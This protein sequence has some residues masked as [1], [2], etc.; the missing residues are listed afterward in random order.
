MKQSNFLSLNWRDL[1]RAF[2]VALITFLLDFA[3]NVFLPSLNIPLEV[4]ALIAY[5]LKNAFTKPD[6][7]KIVGDRPQTSGGR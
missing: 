2:V 6:A 5:L 7:Q 4:K 1:L 3:E